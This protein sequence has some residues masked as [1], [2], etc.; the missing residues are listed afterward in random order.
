MNYSQ[1]LTNELSTYLILAD[2]LKAQYAE[3][4]EETLKDT[5]EGLSLLP[6]MIEAIVRASLEDEALITGLKARLQEMQERLSRLKERQEKKRALV[7]WAMEK[8]GLEKHQAPDF[9]V[10]LRAGTPRLEVISEEEIPGEYFVPQ[11]ARLDR[12]GL[13]SALKRGDPIKGARLSLGDR[14]ITVRVR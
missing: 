4:D 12:L 9:S 8:A 1:C 5:L 13:L 6:E 7:S 10:F 3:I 14:G 2:Q 11:P